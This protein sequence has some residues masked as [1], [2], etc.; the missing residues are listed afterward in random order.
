MIRRHGVMSPPPHDG[1]PKPGLMAAG[2]GLALDHASAIRTLLWV[3]AGA[4][5]AVEVLL[6]AAP[7]G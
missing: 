2:P 1:P 5:G 7:K 6:S 3:V 4:L